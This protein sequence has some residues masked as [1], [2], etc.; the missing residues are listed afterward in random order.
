MDN[1]LPALVKNLEEIPCRGVAIHRR[2]GDVVQSSTCSLRPG[3]L[4]QDGKIQSKLPRL[5][6]ALQDQHRG[7]TV[8]R[9]GSLF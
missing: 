2:R 5:H 1:E 3:V 7:H 6:K 9:L 8:H 4:V